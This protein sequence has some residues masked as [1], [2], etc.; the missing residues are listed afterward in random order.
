MRTVRNALFTLGLLVILVFS[1]EA[2][3]QTAYCA[4]CGSGGTV[5]QTCRQ[6]EGAAYH[7]CRDLGYP[8]SYCN[9]V[10][11]D[12]YNGCVLLHGCPN[13]TY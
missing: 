4:D 10:A 12:T 13:L 11:R 2:L 8:E 5:D 7:D 6:E 3:T 1:T 9:G